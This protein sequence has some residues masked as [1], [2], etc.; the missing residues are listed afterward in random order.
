MGYFFLCIYHHAFHSSAKRGCPPTSTT[1]VRR[2]KKKVCCR[3]TCSIYVMLHSSQ[4]KYP[5]LHK[6]WLFRVEN[7]KILSLNVGRRC[8]TLVFSSMTTWETLY[9]IGSW[10]VFITHFN[11]FLASSQFHYITFYLQF[12]LSY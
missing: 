10:H 3:A 8:I 5:L 6:E 1:L 2:Q 4:M 7:S 12:C 11:I 9:K